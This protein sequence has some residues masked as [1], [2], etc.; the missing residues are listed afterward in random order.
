M[1]F[2]PQE[3]VLG[4]DVVLYTVFLNTFH[5]SP[6]TTEYF[7]AFKIIRMTKVVVRYGIT[8]AVNG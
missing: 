1:D 7:T 5:C 8:L 6:R 4:K 3:V 2:W